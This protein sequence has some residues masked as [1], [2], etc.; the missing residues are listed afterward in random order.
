MSLS[1]EQH[2]SEREASY[3]NERE[4]SFQ[5][6][7]DKIL[8][9]EGKD[10]S[11]PKM[12]ARKGNFTASNISRLL[13]GGTGATR[14]S[15]ILEV[16]LVSIG[17]TDDFDNAAMRHG[18]H[19]EYDSF[20]GLYPTIFPDTKCTWFDKYIPF[21]ANSGASPDAII[22]DYF[23]FDIKH[24]F[25][26]YEYIKQCK[27][28]PKKYYDQSQMQMMSLKAPLGY[29]CMV[30]VKPEKWGEENYKDYPIPLTQRY[31]CH[32][33]HA[34][35]QRQYEI[36]LAVEKAVPARDALIEKLKAAKVIDEMEFFYEQ[37]KHYCYRPI[38]EASN[39]L[40]VD[41]VRVNDEFY[42]KV[43]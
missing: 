2:L 8:H 31:H 18:K 7:T 9:L 5:A 16:A 21:D 4:A 1:S 30:L 39:M 24:P 6:N 43:K 37:L 19:N 15:Y 32:T 34:D 11:K 3:Y 25:S 35:E 12:E 13:A 20:M 40:N 10:A 33:I 41:F 14:M 28:L 26:T 23:P 27:Q 29:M 17:I 42:Y 36:T 22:S 38:K